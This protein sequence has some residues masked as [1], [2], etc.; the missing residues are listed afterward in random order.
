MRK[1]IIF[2]YVFA[3][4]FFP[5]FSFG[6]RSP[7]YQTLSG[8]VNLYGNEPFTY[9]GLKTGKGE[10]FTLTVA[11]NSEQFNVP[12]GFTAVES[13]DQI[14]KLSGSHADFLGIVKKSDGGYQFQTL[15]DGTF[16]VFA[17]KVLK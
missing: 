1:Y 2:S 16:A 8:A 4:L 17:Y 10:Q 12:S 14:K 11:E 3:F 15:K 9:A 6:G 5:L 13:L 7:A